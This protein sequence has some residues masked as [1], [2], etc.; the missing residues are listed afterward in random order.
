MGQPTL[1]QSDHTQEDLA[2]LDYMTASRLVQ[3]RHTLKFKIPKLTEA[4]PNLQG[5]VSINEY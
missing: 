2:K 1:A 5:K 3:T 4:W